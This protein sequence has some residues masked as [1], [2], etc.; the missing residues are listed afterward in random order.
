M[1]EVD[2]F[3]LM[4]LPPGRPFFK[5]GDFYSHFYFLEE[6][7]VNVTISQISIEVSAPMFLGDY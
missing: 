1:I 5:K 4:E 6:G 7:K 3:P 2:C